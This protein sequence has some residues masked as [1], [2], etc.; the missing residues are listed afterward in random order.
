MTYIYVNYPDHN[1]ERGMVYIYEKE[2]FRSATI[3]DPSW[4][5]VIV[6]EILDSDNFACFTQNENVLD[7]NKEYKTE[8]LQNYIKDI[9]NII[10]KLLPYK[11]QYK[12]ELYELTGENVYL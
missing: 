7:L 5:C 6:A 12:K 2:C 1:L 10:A 11:D 9:D 3:S 8:K 4:E